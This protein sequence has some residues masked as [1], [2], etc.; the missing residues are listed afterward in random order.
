MCDDIGFNWLVNLN[1]SYEQF[2][3]CRTLDV[4]LSCQRISP[5]SV[6]HAPFY[7]AISAKYALI[8]D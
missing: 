2:G 5:L 6:R 1:E 3:P 4:Q 8:Q 7:C